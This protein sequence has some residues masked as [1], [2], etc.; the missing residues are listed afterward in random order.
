LNSAFKY[1]GEVNRQEKI[2]FLTSLHVLSVPTTYQ[3]PKGLFVLEA[4]ANGV[5]VVQPQHGAFPELISSSGGGILVEP[6]S[7]QALAEGILKLFNDAP[8]R[9]RL[10]EQGK[11]AVSRAFSDE[12]MA[13]ATWEVYRQY[14]KAA[15]GRD[16]F[17]H[18]DFVSPAPEGATANIISKGSH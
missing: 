13:D 16:A 10:G 4:L 18:S 12:A 11:A 6:N 3:E 8:L 17:G 14:R 9:E 2:N 15:A 1:Y 7:P 5:P